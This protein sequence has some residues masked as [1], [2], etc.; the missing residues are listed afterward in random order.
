MWYDVSVELFAVIMLIIFTTFAKIGNPLKSL[1]NKAFMKLSVCVIVTCITDIVSALMINA[2]L[3]GHFIHPVLLYAV[4]I[5]FFML[6]TFSGVFYCA[7]LYALIGYEDF[8]KTAISAI[9]AVP[10][11]L[12]T[13]LTVTTPWTKLLFYIDE[14]GAYRFGSL[15]FLATAVM[16]L[17]VVTGI[18]FLFVYR[19]NI[20]R[21]QLVSALIFTLGA[22]LGMYIQKLFLPDMSIGMAASALTVIMLNF[23]VQ[24]PDSYRLMRTMEELQRAKKQAED[25]KKAKELF[26]ANMSHEIRTPINSVLGMNEMIIHKS[27][28][29]EILKYAETARKSGVT[30]LTLINNVLD[31]TKLSTGELELSSEPFES[32]AFF[33]IIIDEGAA[34]AK[35]KGLYFK[36][37]IPADFPCTLQGDSLRI[38]QIIQNFISNAVKFTAEG[39]ITFSV[40]YKSAG[41]NAVTVDFAVSDTGCGMEKQDTERIFQSFVRLNSAGNYS[42][43]GAGLGL[44]VSEEL[45]EIMGGRISVESE[46]GV[47]STFTFTVDI[48][49]KDTAPL[50]GVFVSETSGE[51][52]CG[53]DVNIYAPEARVLAAD[54]CEVN[55]FIISEL[56]K[57]FGIRADIAAGG[58]Q[59]IA[60]AAENTYDLIILDHMMPPPDGI[61][62]MHTIKDTSGFAS[63]TSPIIVLT[64]NAVVGAREQY[65]KEGFDG[66]M[67]KPV[68]FKALSEILQKYL[69]PHIVHY[70]EKDNSAGDDIL[71]NVNLTYI[72]VKSAVKKCGGME[73]YMA[74]LRRFAGRTADY[75]ARLEKAA[76]S[77]STD[78]YAEIA[79]QVKTGA[80]EIGA[81][82]LSDMAK[83]Q[84]MFAG[85]GRY[86]DVISLHRDFVNTL[87]QVTAEAEKNII[88]KAEQ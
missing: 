20:S 71:S 30:L 35:D 85:I 47:G 10:L 34:M 68:T 37:D 67:S 83:L 58:D 81:A 66:Y 15:H 45:A 26:L 80:E 2:Q 61:K 48:I 32:R 73:A 78:E 5:V 25:A 3:D 7:Y 8:N 42:L 11:V 79:A 27:T 22:A 74:V 40:S 28:D 56:L 14:N 77:K 19:N 72:D 43:E 49:V 75:A 9:L 50:G 18:A 76:E 13:L 6:M 1:Q 87:V 55:L 12:F 62:V 38:H 51:S 23:S 64:A 52:G 53:S 88:G 46:R 33:D 41:A 65:I 82:N 86:E 69:P 63:N 31:H 44:S 24:T 16:S 21:L 17:Y 54:D 4:N 57:Q 29:P 36:A 84:E 59:C 60:L 39:G 70:I